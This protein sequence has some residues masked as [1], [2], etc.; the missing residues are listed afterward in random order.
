M[1]LSKARASVLVFLGWAAA[2]ALF[3]PR[4]DANSLFTVTFAPDGFGNVVATGTGSID[5]TGL[6]PSG[7]ASDPGFV[8]PSFPINGSYEVTGPKASVNESFYTNLTGP[9]RFGSGA[10][11][12]ADSGSGDTVGLISGHG[13][14][15]PVGYTSGAALSSTSTYDNTDLATLGLTPGTYVS[16]WSNGSFEVDI[17]TVPIPEPGS[18]VLV[19]ICGA[20]F[21]CR[22]RSRRRSA[23]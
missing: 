22:R 7:T 15:V 16:T 6:S 4:A 20:A 13:L 9:A 8:W 5:L 1:H 17:S 18:I 12:V 11:V 3:A 10:Q 21:Y 19:A 2:F 14:Y 23:S